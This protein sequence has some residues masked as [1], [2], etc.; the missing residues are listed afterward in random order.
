MAAAEPPSAPAWPLAP[1]CTPASHNAGC[2]TCTSPGSCSGTTQR[3]I[4]VCRP[5]LL[6]QQ[7]EA[8]RRD[9]LPK[10]P[11]LQHAGPAKPGHNQQDMTHP[12]PPHLHQPVVLIRRKRAVHEGLQVVLAGQ[13]G[14]QGRA[15]G[16]CD[17]CQHLASVLPHV[18]AV[19]DVQPAQRPAKGS[20]SKDRDKGLPQAANQAQATCEQLQRTRVC[21]SRLSPS[22]SLKRAAFCA[23]Q[24]SKQHSS[25]QQSG[26]E[27]SGPGAA[28][29]AQDSS[30]ENLI[31]LLSSSRGP[32]LACAP[33]SPAPVRS[34]DLHE[35]SV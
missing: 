14:R 1:P 8:H 31:R 5:L 33:P 12:W 6:P 25:R 15:V 7:T 10:A 34:P 32:N 23:A 30:L 17:C 28:G 29:Q 26:T 18:V 11:H 9:R 35:P 21:T 3:C 27:G 13:A 20:S 4:R 2:P 19:A 16:A 22:V 24:R